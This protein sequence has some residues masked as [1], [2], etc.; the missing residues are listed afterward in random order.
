MDIGIRELKNKLSEYLRL[1]KKGETLTVTEHGKAIA[2]LSPAE[3]A[4]EIEAL[5]DFL[6]KGKATWNGGKPEGLK[7]RARISGKPVSQIVIEDRR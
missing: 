2:Y 4:A 1:V 5:L 7:R 3:N 6:R